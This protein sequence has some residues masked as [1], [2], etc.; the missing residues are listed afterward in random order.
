[1]GRLDE[2]I[3]IVTGA[4]SGIGRASA[5][6]FAREGAFVVVNDLSEDAAVE[7]VAQIEGAGGRAIAR[8]ADV[9]DPK[10][11]DE[12][13]QRTAAEHGRLD[14]M[15]N[16]AGGAVPEPTHA[17]SVEAYRKVIAL[18]LD[19]A[20]FGSQSAL[21]VMLEQRSGCILLTTSGAGLAAV[22]HF[23]AYGAAKAG[24]VN[25]GRSI[26][27]E[28]GPFGIRANVIAPGPMDTPAVAAVLEQRQ[29]AREQIE[30]QVP[31]R[32]LGTPEDIAT[33][34]AFLASDAASFVTGAT[35]PVDGGVAGMLNSPELEPES[36]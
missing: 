13:V 15:Y 6:E 20:F 1:M 27:A 16:N 32:R 21:R 9:T 36:T 24:I 19:S 30:S 31:M 8:P 29:G 17:M 11:V 12:L 3:S 23:A 14:V 7:T 26:A 28:Y 2:K 33:T 35:I 18:N 25:L 4:G 5:I 10:Q 22:L 34:A